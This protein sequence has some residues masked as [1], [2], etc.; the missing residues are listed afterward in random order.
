MEEGQWER[1]LEA[2]PLAMEAVPEG[3]SRMRSSIPMGQMK[4]HIV[5]NHS[6]EQVMQA[7]LQA[8][9]DDSSYWAAWSTLGAACLGLEEV[10][11][12]VTSKALKLAVPAEAPSLEL[13]FVQKGLKE[14]QEKAAAQRSKDLQ[15][16]FA[17]REAEFAASAPEVP[18]SEVHTEFVRRAVADTPNNRLGSS[19]W[20][21]GNRKWNAREQLRSI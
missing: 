14:A 17:D 12:A 19:D 1:G 18:A 6:R 7:A 8:T 15:T 4:C 2:A 11:E 16:V 20:W 9:M 13:E 10:T 3:E 5:L 21:S